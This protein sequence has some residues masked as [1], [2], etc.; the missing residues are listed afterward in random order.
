[1]WLASG[2][3]QRNPAAVRIHGVLL[4][5]TIDARIVSPDTTG[6][7]RPVAAS[8][9]RATLSPRSKAIVPRTVQNAAAR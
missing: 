4:E 8:S 1:M 5:T 2:V 3:D 6:V 7:E 9:R